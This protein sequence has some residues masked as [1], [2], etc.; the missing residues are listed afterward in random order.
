MAHGH[1]KTA[2]QYKLNVIA[3]HQQEVE[4]AKEM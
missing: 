3:Q 1:G 4:I 2:V